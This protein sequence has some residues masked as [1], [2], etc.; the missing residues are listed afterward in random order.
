MFYRT[1]D[2]VVPDYTTE[3]IRKIFR[4]VAEGRIKKKASNYSD[5]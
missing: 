2:S 5:L 3:Y 1:T 4:K